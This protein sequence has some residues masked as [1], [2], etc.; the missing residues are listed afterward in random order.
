MRTVARWAKVLGVDATMQADFLAKAGKLS[1]YALTTDP[2][3]GNRT[4]WSEALVQR[5]PGDP[6][7]TTIKGNSTPFH[8]N[9]MYPIVQFA[10]M[11]PCGLVNMDS[12]P[13]TLE[14]A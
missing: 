9:Y 4:V 1:S 7:P 5:F 6:T 2:S 3:F 10:P 13:K 8:A 14:L 12:D 11:H